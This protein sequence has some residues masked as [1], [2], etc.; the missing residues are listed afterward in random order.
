M[1]AEYP[2]VGF[3]FEVKFELGDATDND[4][5]FQ[6]VIGLTAEIGVETLPEG[7][8]NRFAHRL[9]GRAKYGNLVLKRGLTTDTGLIG[10]FEA[11]VP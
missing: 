3:H 11:A 7:G 8:E 5:R 1:A 6:K 9:P 4:S 10:W 2:P